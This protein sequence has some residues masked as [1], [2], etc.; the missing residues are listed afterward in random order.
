MGLSE[1]L[2]KTFAEQ[3]SR[4]C[5]TGQ[6]V[7]EYILVLFITVS[8]I[9][10]LM[11]Q[12]S[13]AFK[14]FLDSY[15]GDYIAC[16][17]ETGELPSLGGSGPNQSQCQ[18]PFVNF[19]LA[20]G[21]SIVEPSSGGDGSSD[22]G[23]SSSAGSGGSSGSSSGSSNQPLRSSQVSSSGATGNSDSTGRAGAG[24]PSRFTQRQ[25]GGA[26][27]QQGGFDSGSSDGEFST[28]RGRRI[29]RRRRIYLQDDY[30]TQ[31]AKKKN[32]NPV[33][34]SAKKDPKSVGV[35]SLR[36]PKF[37]L[38]VPKPRAPATDSEFK[39]FSFATLIKFLLIAGIVIAIV[40]FLG[41]QAL[42]IK[43]SWEKGE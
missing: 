34:G 29:V 19:N 28:G 12:F 32:R 31:D 33:I 38:E 43:K 35:S 11:Y 27:Q 22:G 17:L 30:L 4:A 8:L 24:R 15:F 7:V 18:A 36:Q 42:Q 26:D 10:G 6:A 9:L 5:E 40:I 2:R 20:A 16:L 13:D 21:N 1:Y 25:S 23:S 3:K 41:G 39:G 37:D 14:Q